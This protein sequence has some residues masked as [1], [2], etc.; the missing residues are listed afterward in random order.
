MIKYQLSKEDLLQIL[1]EFHAF[2]VLN[3][4]IIKVLSNATGINAKKLCEQHGIVYD[5]TVK[6]VYPMNTGAYGKIKQDLLQ[7]GYEITS[8]TRLVIKFRKD[9]N[10]VA[11]STQGFS[12]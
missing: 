4:R 2:N 11:L 5:L 8:R 7:K 1:C 9:N 3:D 10:I 6:N 12:D